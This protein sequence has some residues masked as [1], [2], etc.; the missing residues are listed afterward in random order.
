MVDEF[1]S[2]RC[3]R[4]V[5]VQSL[6]G[7]RIEVA[8]NTRTRL[9]G[10]SLLKLPITVV[11]RRA[12]AAFQSRTWWP[13]EIH[14]SRFPSVL[15]AFDP[16]TE[17][18]WGDLIGLSLITSDNDAANVLLSELPEE[19]IDAFLSE[20]GCRGTSLT[21]DF[22]DLNLSGLSREN[23]ITAEDIS[24]ILTIIYRSEPRICSQ[25]TNDLRNQRIPRLLES[26]R[27][28]PV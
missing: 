13:M 2:G 11:A 8:R 4:S 16:S 26:P 24:R 12:E 5:L 14:D 9:Q 20:A 19:S 7:K 22:S 10:A 25:M 17:L 1:V 27:Q 18:S 6:R 23:L 15:A 3:D 21:S 28:P